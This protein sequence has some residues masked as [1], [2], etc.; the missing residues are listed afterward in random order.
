MPSPCSLTVIPPPHPPSGEPTSTLQTRLHQQSSSDT[1]FYTFW[2]F[3]LAHS[4][5]LALRAQG[6]ERDAA[7][8]LGHDRG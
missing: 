3:L 8:I 4:Q 5:T 7:G 6:T 2:G 1:V